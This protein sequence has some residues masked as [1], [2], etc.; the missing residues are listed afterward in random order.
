MHHMESYL[1]V[2]SDFHI[3]RMGASVA[4]KIPNGH[5]ITMVDVVGL[6][7]TRLERGWYFQEFGVKHENHVGLCFPV[8]KTLRSV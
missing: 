7:D 5:T 8:H 4:I 1:H 3:V 6:A 2:Y